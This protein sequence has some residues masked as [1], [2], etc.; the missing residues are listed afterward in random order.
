MRDSQSSMLWASLIS[1]VGVVIVIVAGF[2]GARH[3]LLAN[4]V[5]MI[6]MAWSFGYAVLVVGHLNILS[7][8]FTATLIGIGI[9]YGTYYVARYL[10]QRR[11]G[12]DIAHSFAHH[13]RR[14]RAKHHHRHVHD[15][16]FILHGR[17]HQLHWRCRTRHHRW[18]RVDIGA[19]AQLYVLPVCIFLTDRGKWAHQLPNSLAVQ[20]G[21]APFWR[22]PRT[23]FFGGIAVTVLFAFGLP[24]L[25][26]DYNLLNLQAD[27]LSSVE[28]E[29]KLLTESNQ[30]A[31]YAT[32]VA[33]S[34]QELL[35]RKE[36][37]SRLPCVERIEEIVSLFP[38]DATSKQPTIAAVAHK[39][40]N[41][42][43]AAPLIAVDGQAELGMILAQVKQQLSQ[44]P[45]AQNVVTQLNALQGT[46][47]HCRRKNTSSG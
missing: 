3:A 25:W 7:V 35:R 34:P 23:L 11:E 37:F 38:V 40:S 24:K 41:L 44:L 8:T 12:Q 33:N 18:R 46:I 22:R 14:C 10:Q 13:V 1:F 2:G 47:E 6:G 42:P 45:E 5:L 4:S 31:W 39:T 21:F 43:A 28:W 26:Y 16:D 19:I 32:S 15:R 36:Q 9:D 20:R 17:L 30:S 27:G 29:R